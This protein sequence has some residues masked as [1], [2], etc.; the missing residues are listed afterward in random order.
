MDEVL[1]VV[2]SVE[3]IES[4]LRGEPRLSEEVSI[5]VNDVVYHLKPASLRDMPKIGKNLKIFFEGINLDA[6][7]V[8]STSVDDAIKMFTSEKMI[9]VAETIH[10]SLSKKDRESVTIDDILDNCDLKTF[11]RS[12]KSIMGMNDFF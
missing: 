6:G 7:A 3:D 11:L 5:R 12:I 2:E 10:L 1:K 4:D 9:A 8:D